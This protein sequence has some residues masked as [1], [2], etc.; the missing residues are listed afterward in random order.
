MGKRKLFETKSVGLE[1]SLTE[2]SY[3]DATIG[4]R[5]RLLIVNRHQQVRASYLMNIEDLR[6]LHV[7]VTQELARKSGAF[8]QRRY[9][10]S[11][12]Q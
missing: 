9:G 3:D 2:Q 6:G 4:L 12:L 10:Q 5:Y 11:G 1:L 8:R 7:A